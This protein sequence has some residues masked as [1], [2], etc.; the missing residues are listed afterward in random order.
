MGEWWLLCGL[1]RAHAW[2][3]QVNKSWLPQDMEG[4]ASGQVNRWIGGL[5]SG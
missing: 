1:K 2:A 5:A 3:W 4:R